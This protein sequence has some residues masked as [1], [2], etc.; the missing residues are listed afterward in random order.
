MLH[1]LRHGCRLAEIS[2]EDPLVW[3]FAERPPMQLDRQREQLTELR[4]HT[5]GLDTAPN[6]LEMALRPPRERH[7]KPK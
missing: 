4:A 5:V 7:R 3:P 6:R 1:P 2:L